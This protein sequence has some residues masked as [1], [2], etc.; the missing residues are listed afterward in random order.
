MKVIIFGNKCKDRIAI[1]ARQL[2]NSL[3]KRNVSIYFEKD[4][5]R[6]LVEK[7]IDMAFPHQLLCE[8][9]D[10][11]A[12]MAF[13]IG[14]DGT[15]IKTSAKIGKKNIPIIGINAG[16][17]GFLAD[18]AGDEIEEAVKEILDGKYKIE[19]RTLL[20]L[21]TKEKLYKDFNYALNEIAVMKR[22]SS[23]MITIDAW[24]ND[25]FINSYQADGLLI[26][27][28]TGSTAYSMSVGGPIVVPQAPN[29]IIT[30]IAPHSLNVRPI[31]IP[32]DWEI[33]L[34]VESR[35]NQF[36][37][38]LDGRNNIF[39]SKTHLIIKKAGFTTKVVK[40]ENNDFFDTL[41]SKLMWGMSER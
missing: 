1:Y 31:I 11:E 37:I 5:C 16:R 22:D 14:G 24:A 26:S 18:I 34:R 7:G 9:E 35:N 4:F 33:K 25:V 17:L 32:D 39:D 41:R 23:S 2:V 12:D 8:G 13:S 36:L 28:S 21:Y 40:R 6:F 15:F 38:A 10:F 30:P 20:R 19:D 29:F 27:T 3:L